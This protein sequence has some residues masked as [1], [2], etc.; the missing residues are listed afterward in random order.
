MKFVKCRQCQFCK[1]MDGQKG[2]CTADIPACIARNLNIDPRER[3]VP[4]C[5][6]MAVFCG[7]FKRKEV[8]E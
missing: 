7:C 8:T 1:T 6:K 3:I 5:S 4:L 2:R